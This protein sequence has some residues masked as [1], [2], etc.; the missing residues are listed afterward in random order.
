MHS[1]QLGTKLECLP[2]TAQVQS[3]Y[4]KEGQHVEAGDALI[5][6]DA[7]DASANHGSNRNSDFN[8]NEGGSRTR[9][10]TR[11]DGAGAGVGGGQEM[12]SLRPTILTPTAQQLQQFVPSSSLLA[13]PHK[14]PSTRA[15]AKAGGTAA[16]EAEAEAESLATTRIEQKLDTLLQVQQAQA[17]QLE[18][19]QAALKQMA[20]ALESLALVTTT[21][22]TV[23]EAKKTSSL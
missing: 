19:Q 17:Q 16:A 21:T 20:E 6:F 10:R 18:A 11:S 9:R 1:K 2:R 23:A 22:A 15:K 8:S 14:E 4:V 12:S 3:I 7:T 5:D 13:S